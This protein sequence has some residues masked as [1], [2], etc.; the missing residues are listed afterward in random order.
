MEKQSVV[1]RILLTI[2]FAGYGLVV[3]PTVI[4]TVVLFFGSIMGIMVEGLASTNG[5]F[6]PTFQST[7]AEP[8]VILFVLVNLFAFA[9]FALF[10]I[11]VLFDFSYYDDNIFDRAK[12]IVLY[13]NPIN[14][15]LILPVKFILQCMS[16]IYKLHS[17]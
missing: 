8:V 6:S 13:W 10:L 15:Y 3:I 7:I 4:S 2:K 9:F 14:I 17:T 5:I 16:R 1:A 11:G 12:S